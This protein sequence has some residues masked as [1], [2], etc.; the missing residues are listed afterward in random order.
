MSTAFYPTNMR[1]QSASGYSNKSTLENIPYVSW[2][3]SGI[4]SNPVGVTST[5]I[6][7][8]TN[9]DP[10]NVFPTGFGLPRPIKHYRKGTVIPI[11]FNVI[12][13]NP[14]NTAEYIGTSLIGYNV[15]R[16][17]KSSISSS[18]GGGN[19]GTGLISQMIDMPGSFIVKENGIK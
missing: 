13:V 17:V 14:E 6:R 19:G 9:L 15:N 7:P 5:H 10:G 1:R 12:T 16:A 2:K 3:G 18:L 4:F 11:N 8:L